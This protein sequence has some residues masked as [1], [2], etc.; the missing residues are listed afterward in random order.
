MAAVPAPVVEKPKTKKPGC[1]AWLWPLLGIIALLALIL[2]LLFG[3][4][5]FGGKGGASANALTRNEG[6]TVM[7]EQVILSKDTN[8]NVSGSTTTT[9]T[10]S[11]TTGT[12]GTKTNT[13]STTSTTSNTAGTTSTQTN[14]T[15]TTIATSSNSI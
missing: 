6:Y 13:T 10:N 8:S 12:T 11:N 2:G 15:G 14:M 3:L 5:V 7:D 1:P 4:G 9:G